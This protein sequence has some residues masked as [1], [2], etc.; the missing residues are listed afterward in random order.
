MEVQ[1]DRLLALLNQLEAL[2]QQSGR[3]DA[4]DEILASPR[5]NTL[6]QSLR[7]H[8]VVKQFRRE[9]T[10]GFVRADTAHRLLGVLAAA[11]EA[12]SA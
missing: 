6:V 1:S 4:I 9:L 3:G 12:L 5:R 10:G 7:D 8:E 11:L 2:L